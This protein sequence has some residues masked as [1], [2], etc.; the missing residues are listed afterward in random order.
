LVAEKIERQV[1]VLNRLAA[2]YSDRKKGNHFVEAANWL[3]GLIRRVEHGSTM[4]IVRGIEGKASGLKYQTFEDLPFQLRPRDGKLVPPYWL[5][6][7][8]RLSPLTGSGRSAVTPANALGNIA[9]AALASQCRI[10]IAASG[11]D[12]RCE[13]LHADRGSRDNLVYDVMEVYRPGVDENII[14]FI[15]STVLT[16]GHFVSV[17][18]GQ[19]KLHPALA[20]AVVATC[21]LK[22]SEIDVG[23]ILGL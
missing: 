13:F 7:G 5:T 10:A 20:K 19:C 12:P 3:H 15:V 4:V 23:P 11:L 17:S 21:S 22:W 9:F 16:Y 6:V 8:P 18:N 1:Q 14:R 2:M